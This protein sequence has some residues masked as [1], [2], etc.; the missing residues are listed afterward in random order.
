M[1]E[2]E[3]LR[4][5]VR[6]GIARITLARPESGNAIDFAMRR[7]LRA[8]IRMVAEDTGIRA[9]IIDGEGRNFC[10]GGDISAMKHTAPADGAE[11]RERLRSYIDLV[12]QLIMLEKPAVA[13]VHGHA[14]GAGC[15]L[16]L[17]ADLVVA[18]TD[19][20]FT[21]SFARVGLVPD[22]GTFYTL[23]R[24]VGMQKARQLIYS[25]RP[26]VA[27]E[28]LK[29]GMVFD[30]V[31]QDCLTDTATQLA[32]ALCSGSPTAFGLAKQALSR[33]F[34]VDLRTLLEFEAS[35]QGICF[36]TEWHRTAVQRFL[37]KHPSPF[38]GFSAPTGGAS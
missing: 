31:E 18:S 8:A 3:T 25:A 14:A 9:V 36:T 35:A 2:F 15:G 38:Q 13:A 7:E 24:L 4:F 30:V 5:A 21:L 1:A 19:A 23:P 34:D 10:T 29:I 17:A 26:V 6:K 20:A 37:D 16:A 11:G 22:F 27:A 12:E 32:A 28:A 33:S